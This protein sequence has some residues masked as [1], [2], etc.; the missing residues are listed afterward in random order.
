MTARRPW[1]GVSTRDWFIYS[2][3]PHTDGHRA[4]TAHDIGGHRLLAALSTTMKARTIRRTWSLPTDP[5]PRKPGRYAV[6][7]AARVTD[8]PPSSVRS[9]YQP[10]A[11]WRGT[12]NTT[13]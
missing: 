8:R 6:D 11:M 1:S 13:A 9:A 3:T 10:V 5:G 12:T 2:D 4:T 7:V